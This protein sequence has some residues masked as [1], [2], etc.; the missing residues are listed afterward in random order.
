[1]ALFERFFGQYGEA[2][3]A[4]VISFVSTVI[5]LVFGAYYAQKI[6]DWEK[7]PKTGRLINKKTGQFVGKNKPKKV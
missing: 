4:M 2:T 5:C 1:V 7:D 3:L 6:K